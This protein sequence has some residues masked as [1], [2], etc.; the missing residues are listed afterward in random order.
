MVGRPSIPAPSRLSTAGPPRDGLGAVIDFMARPT[1]RILAEIAE[2]RTEL[3]TELREFRTEMRTE[4]HRLDERVDGTNTR[5]DTVVDALAQ[6][7]TA[8]HTHD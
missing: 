5:L 2:L 6:L 1:T 8:N 4:I 7:R 3:R